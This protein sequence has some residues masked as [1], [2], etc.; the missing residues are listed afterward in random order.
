MEISPFFNSKKFPCS[1]LSSNYAVCTCTAL[2]LPPFAEVT[3]Q[4]SQPRHGPPRPFRLRAAYGMSEF[5]LQET[6]SLQS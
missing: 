6:A 2:Y 1:L 3:F 4:S 5:Q